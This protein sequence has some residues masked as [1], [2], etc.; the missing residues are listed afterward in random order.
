MSLGRGKRLIERLNLPRGRSVALTLGSLG[1]FVLGFLPQ[2]AGPGYE[3]ALLSGIVLPSIAS[4][5]VAL[6]VVGARPSASDAVARGAAFGALLAALGLLVVL[7]HG[8]R[9]GFC[10][11]SEGLWLYA[12]GPG[13][14]TVLGGV[15]GAV[16][17]FLLSRSRRPERRWARI[18]V[19]VLLALAG[20]V[21]GIVVSV[22]RFYTSPMVFAFDPYAGA[23]AG[24]LY[25]TV[26]SIVDRLVTYRHGTAL[27]LG[28]LFLAARLLDVSLESPSGDFA[29][30]RGVRSVLRERPGLA[31]LGVAAL[32]GSLWHSASGPRFGH[33]STVSSIT[34]TL[35]GRHSG[36]RCDVVFAR[37]LPLRDVE[38]FARDCDAALAQVEKYFGAKGPERVKVFLFANEGDKG[39]LM[40]A[41]RTYIAKPWRHEVYLQA[42]P[43]PHP[44]IEHELAHVVAGSFGRGP[45]RVAGPLGGIWPDPGRIE[46]FAVA[47]AL[48]HDDELTPEQWAA[49]MLKLGLLPKLSQVFELDFL[50]FNA[51]KAYTVAGAF[52]GWLRQTHGSAAIRRWYGGETLEAVTGGKGLA[53]LEH[54]FRAALGRTPVPERALATAQARFEKPSFFARRCP[55]IVDRALGEA[56]QRLE[57]GDVKG[58]REGFDEVLR[59]DAGNVE[60][61]FG[62]AGCARRAGDAERAISLHLALARA[63]DVP[64]VQRARALETVGDI[65]L[66]RGRGEAAKLHF[67]EAQKLVF[68][69]DRQRTLDVKRLAAEGSGRDAIVALLVGEDDLGPAWDVAAPLIQAWAEREPSSDIPPYLLGRNV[70]ATGRYKHAAGYFDRSLALEP[71][72]ASVRREALRLRAI[73]ACGLGDHEALRSALE[74]AIADPELLAAR[75][76]G[77]ERLAERCGHTLVAKTKTSETTPDAAPTPAT[78]ACPLGMLPLPGGKFW[79]GSE[80][81]EARS[82]DESPRYLTELAPF[83]LDETE[84]TVKAYGDCVSAGRCEKPERERILCNFGREERKA[85]PI[86]CLSWKLADGYCKLRGARLPTEAEFEYAARGGDE[87]RKYPWGDATPDGN[88]CWKH[89]G[90][91]DVKTFAAG[92]FGLFDVNGNVWEWTDDWYGPYPFPPAT[93]FAKVYRGGSFSRRFEKWMNP[94]L[95]NRASPKDDSAQIGFR[96]ALTLDTTRCPFGVESPGRCRHGVRELACGDGKSFNGVRCVKPGEPRCPDGWAEKSGYGC[97][98]EREIEPE[99]EDVQAAVA[100]VTNARSPEFDGDCAANAPGRPR[101]FRYAGGSHAAR[102]QVSKSAGCKN[103]DVGVGWNSTCCP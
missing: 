102:N 59:L 4:I 9:V 8:V 19:A 39:W 49:S 69:E 57:V 86:N 90:S 12:L 58:A 103:R 43:F 2:F 30:S 79:V 33:W 47:A 52:V 66:G 26:V 101:A 13:V 85:H 91:C 72:L 56:V 99:I 3:A 17:G 24:P 20:P 42:A 78:P 73:A 50:G 82:P 74:R 95:R 23:F 81:K 94:R 45:F 48:D 83:C 67:A 46:G 32:V 1:L 41:S 55:R 65:E 40:G 60:A 76:L 10:D 93:G 15:T 84:V 100:L 37:A 71:R 96:C 87:Y 64:K 35:G 36:K 61:R 70:L 11:P 28:A 77:L 16:A 98:L 18:T 31:A 62:L 51:A 25:D 89:N 80:P 21:L 22:I 54:E 88:S 68:A 53:A 5:V 38:L 44:V 92:A 75:R 14:G 34:E 29:A 6:E 63:D 97:L 27:T 7:I